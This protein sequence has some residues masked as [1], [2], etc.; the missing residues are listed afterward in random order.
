MFN[1]PQIISG[2]AD[3]AQIYRASGQQ[4]ERIDDALER[5]DGNIFMDTMD[6]GTVARW[7]SMLGIVPAE[8]EPLENRRSRVKTKSMEKLPYSYRV[9]I[10][11]LDVLCGEGNYILSLDVFSLECQVYTGDVLANVT[12]LMETV[13]PLNI[14]YKIVEGEPI[15]STAYISAVVQDDEVM[16]IEQL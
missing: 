7:E 15:I 4:C 6:E 2:I 1:A 16:E 12:D 8:T 9:L 13:L 5:M 3:I 14:D 11:M 10:R